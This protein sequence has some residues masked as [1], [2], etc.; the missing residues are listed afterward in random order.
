MHLP[1][2]LTGQRCWSSASPFSRE[3]NRAETGTPRAIT[4]GQLI[5]FRYGLM[6]YGSYLGDGAM[7]GP[8]FTGEAPN[9]TARWMNE[10]YDREWAERIPDAEERALFVRA[11]VQKE[12]KRNRYDAATNAVAMSAAQ[13]AAFE[14]L[15][16]YYSQKFGAGGELVGIETFQPANYITDPREIRDLTAFFAGAVGC[17]RRSG[18]GTTTATRT[19]G[20]TIHSR[21]IP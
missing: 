14:K 2:P 15:V 16:R 11:L 20:R 8:D 18:P 9:L 1:E 5:F 10:T 4:D 19:T 12:L 17:A 21:A 13:A 7:R 6:E 3:R